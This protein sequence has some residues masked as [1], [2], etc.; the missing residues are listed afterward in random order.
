MSF[1]HGL[2][3]IGI[4]NVAMPRQ[5]SQLPRVPDDGKLTE[6]GFTQIL[7]RRNYANGRGQGSRLGVRPNRASPRR[8]S[9]GEKLAPEPPLL[10][11]IELRGDR[12][13]PRQVDGVA[14]AAFARQE[15]EFFLEIGR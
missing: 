11:P 12:L 4:A 1:F 8:A 15:Q 3:E 5:D 14:S 7:P 9:G 13:Q 6:I 10:G 2:S